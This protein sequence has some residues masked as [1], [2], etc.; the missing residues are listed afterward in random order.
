QPPASSLQPPASSLQPPACPSMHLKL[1]ISYDGSHF[2]GWQSQCHGKT[3]QD[4]LENAF[5]EIAGRRIVVHGAS[6]TDAGVHALAQVAHVAL[7][8]VSQKMSLP[9]RWLVALNASLPPYVR[10]LRV[11][12]ASGTFHA[13]FCAQSK[14]YRYRLWHD[15][16]LPPLL[17]QRAWQI[18][19]PLDLSLL[20]KISSTLIGTHDF[21][22]FTAKS[23]AARENT[24]RTLHSLK[25]A[26]RGKEIS[27][28][29]HGNGF[30]YHMVRM[31]VG[32]MV[33]VARGKMSS[34]TFLKRL[35]DAKP[36]V[37]PRTA[38]AEGLYL[39]KIFYKS[40]KSC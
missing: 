12:Q 18:H 24:I 7:G 25:I 22:G 30:L 31:L 6:R 35:D 40:N 1:T 38:P 4:I 20:E 28:V 37:A 15:D 13:R 29:F 26:R 14:I 33:H 2:S 16:T 5:A 39:V 36:P 10:I 3:V 8:E 19:G 21:R 23:G 9:E 32:S 11:Q 34:D 17:Y 27:L